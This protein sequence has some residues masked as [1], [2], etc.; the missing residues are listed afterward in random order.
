MYQEREKRSYEK[1]RY[2]VR[3][4]EGVHAWVNWGS[5]AFEIANEGSLA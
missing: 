5:F 2:Q 4:D 3:S 1:T